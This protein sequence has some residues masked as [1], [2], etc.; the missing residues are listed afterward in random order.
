MK[1]EDV[2]LLIF[3]MFYE[4]EIWLYFEVKFYVIMWIYICNNNFLF[5][6]LILLLKIYIFYLYFNYINKYFSKKSL[7]WF[8]FCLSLEI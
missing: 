1:L 4:S 5:I 2:G 8:I 3:Y 6:W 7:K